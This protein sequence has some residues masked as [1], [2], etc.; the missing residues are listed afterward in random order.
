MDVKS[1]F[2]FFI[3][4]FKKTSKICVSRP[5]YPFKEHILIITL[6]QNLEEV[7]NKISF[8]SQTMRDTQKHHDVKF[9]IRK[10]YFLIICIFFVFILKNTIENQ[11]FHFSTKICEIRGNK[12]RKL[13]L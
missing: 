7:N 6:F 11:K 2:C 3:I 12:L 4:K 10:R 9:L 8:F 13:L 1:I 5:E